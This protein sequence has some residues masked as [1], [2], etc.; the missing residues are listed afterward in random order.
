MKKLAIDVVIL[1]P[2][3]IADLCITVNHDDPKR[4]LTLNSTNHLPH[5]TV[6][7]GI[8]KES[9]I[10]TIDTNLRKIAKKYLLI[11]L[12]ITGFMC[13]MNGKIKSC[14][15][16]IKLSDQLIKLQ[17]QI[18][19]Q[20]KPYLI[21]SNVEKAMF[22]DKDI[23]EGSLNWV[24]TFSKAQLG[25]NYKPHITLH[26]S[27]PKYDKLPVKFTASRLALCHLGH[28]CTCRKILK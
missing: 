28:F 8:I 18:I 24:K 4:N 25:K 15:F 13:N 5:I 1:P 7:M 6:L 20:L 10:K 23:S 12:K 27:N 2:K 17:K 21:G 3:R 14:A 26:T 11:N 9:D 19:N 16:D 22:Y